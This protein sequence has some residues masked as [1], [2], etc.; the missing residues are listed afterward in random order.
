M[1]KEL[2]NGILK[3]EPSPNWKKAYARNIDELLA[4]WIT[5][6]A[7]M[8]GHGGQRGSQTGEGLS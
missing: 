8:L 6:V 2:F 5:D 1:A 3:S 4:I 7:S